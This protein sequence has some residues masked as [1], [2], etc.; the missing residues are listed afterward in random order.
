MAVEIV[1][2][3]TSGDRDLSRPIAS[4][5]SDSPF[6]DDI[7]A[8]LML[9]DIDLAV[10]SL[11][12]LPVQP[13]AGL[14]IAAVLERGD[15]AET[16]VSRDNLTLEQLPAGACVGT[17]SPRRAAQ[18][19]RLRPDLRP[20]TIRGPVE[21]RVRQVREGKF[22]AAILA[23][24]GLER[25]GLLHEAAQRFDVSDFVPAP[26]QAT[27]AVQTREDDAA[28]TAHVDSLEHVATR[29]ANMAELEFLRPYEHEDA[30]AVAAHAIVGSTVRLHACVL[31]LD[32]RV[33]FEQ[34]REGDD[35]MI[36]ARAMSYAFGRHM[37]LE[38]GRS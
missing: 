25:L 15:P 22:D 28:A 32:G 10:H 3:G 17:S 19:L 14:T 6:T 36:V 24:A 5:P 21:D 2:I 34:T 26:G 37:P 18:I 12:D 30:F 27:L 13:A 4:L 9:G 29:R 33:L 35:P 31:S 38:G 8:A 20:T 16:L 1:Q 11:K 7:E 23:A